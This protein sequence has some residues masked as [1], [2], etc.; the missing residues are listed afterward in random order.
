[1]FLLNKL[2]YGGFFL[3]LACDLLMHFVQA[4]KQVPHPAPARMGLN[5]SQPEL[6]PAR[7]L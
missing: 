5:Y 2:L 1:M 4:R 7:D 6:T 3:F